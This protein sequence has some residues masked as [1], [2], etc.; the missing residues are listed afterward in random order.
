MTKTIVPT[1][2][3]EPPAQSFNTDA[4]CITNKKFIAS[5]F[6]SFSKVVGALNEKSISF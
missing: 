4:K 3:K 1:K 5:G 6:C 2:T